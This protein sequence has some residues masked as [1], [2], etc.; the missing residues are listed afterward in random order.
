MH[1]SKK[2]HTLSN[3]AKEKGARFSVIRKLLPVFRLTASVFIGMNKKQLI[4]MQGERSARIGTDSCVE[5]VN[6]VGPSVVYAPPLYTSHNQIKTWMQLNGECCCF[7]C[8]HTL[9]S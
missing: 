4:A 6:Q 3:T 2:R 7:H 9:T 8:M 5:H 1:A